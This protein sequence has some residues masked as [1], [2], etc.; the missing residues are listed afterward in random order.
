M[1]ADL[2]AS[3]Q[4]KLEDRVAKAQADLAEWT[5]AL[6]NV[7]ENITAVAGDV[8]DALE[9]D[10][11]VEEAKWADRWAKWDAWKEEW[12]AKKA[13]WAKDKVGG[14]FHE[15]LFRLIRRR[16]STRH[17]QILPQP[18]T[19]R[20]RILAANGRPGS[21]TGRAAS[22]RRSTRLSPME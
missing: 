12:D 4:Q 10:L 14:D 17:K 18:G 15:T 21:M 7:A 20:R 8:A 16:P 22:R 9:A 19:R 5:A 13:V 11:A 1:K 2:K 6:S 3:I